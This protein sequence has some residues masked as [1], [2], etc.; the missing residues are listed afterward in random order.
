MA[1]RGEF[2]ITSYSIH[3]T[4]LY[5]ENDVRELKAG[6]PVKLMVDVLVKGDVDQ[7]YVMINIPIPGSCSYH[8]KNQFNYNWRSVESY[9]EYFK[10]ETAIFCEKMKPGYHRF[11]IDLLP[12]FSG[13][14]VLNP[15]QV[16]LMYFPVVNANEDLKYVK[17]I[18]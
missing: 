2:V 7:E 17:V 3:Y 16:E 1:K 5:D 18:E 13:K 6:Q 8:T 14:Y 4:K 15:A 11:E 12:R 10:E 9:R